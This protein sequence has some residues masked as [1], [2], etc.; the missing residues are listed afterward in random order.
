MKREEILSEVILN[1]NIDLENNKDTIINTNKT[2]S[3][4]LQILLSSSFDKKYEIKLNPVLIKLLL[5]ILKLN[6][7]YFTFVE[8]LFLKIINN[9][10]I[11]SDD[12]PNILLSLKNLYE[13]L[14]VLKNKDINNSVIILK[15]IIN[16][17]MV[18]KSNKDNDLLLSIFT[19]IDTSSELISLRKKLKGK[20]KSL[21]GCF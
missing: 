2:F 6:N 14:Y 7:E 21:L 10:K 5:T 16:V 3:E 18:D 11:N 13:I 17:I 4:R 9:K 20:N 12:V 19:I 1:S 8:E 15:F